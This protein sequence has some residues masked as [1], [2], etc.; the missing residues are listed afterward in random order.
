MDKNFDLRVSLEE[1]VS[2]RELT[3]LLPGGRRFVELSGRPTILADGGSGSMVMLRDVTAHRELERHLVHLG[4]ML[5][6]APYE[7]YV[8]D[9][10]TLHIRFTNVA[11]R[12]ALGYLGAEL[13][14]LTI[15]DVL[16]ELTRGDVRR[17]VTD[18]SG[19]P[20]EVVAV[21]GR[22]RRKD[23]TTY[24]V[25]AR[26]HLVSFADESAI[27][28]FAIDVSARV[29]AEDAQERLRSRMEQAQRFETVQQLAGGIAHEF[30]NLLM[31]VGGHAEMIAGFAGEDRVREWAGRIRAAQER[32]AALIQRL[33]GLARTD[34]AQPTPF[35]LG[36]AL[37]EFLPVLERT[38]GPTVHVAL[39][40]AGRDVVTIDRG[41]MEQIVLHLATNARDAMPT[42][43]TVRIVVRGPA[44][45]AGGDVEM[46]VRDTGQG[47]S[48]ET[49]RRAFDPFFTDKPHGR[50]TGLGLTTVRSIVTQAGGQVE[51]ESTPAAGT[52]ARVRLPASSVQPGPRFAA[53]AAAPEAGEAGASGDI[54]VVEDD[55]DSRA[56]VAHALTHAGYQVRAVATAEEALAWAGERQ[57]DVDLVLT[58]IALPGMT[59][60][61]LGAE[62]AARF[63]PLRVLYMSGYAQQH[64]EG[65]PPGF[66]AAAD[67]LVKPFSADTLLAAVRSVLRRPPAGIAAPPRSV[68]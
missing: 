28:L 54:L 66:D 52:I 34:V 68:T 25:E 16:P 33:Q 47:M 46:D 41:Q 12:Q 31:S 49:V 15:S 19:R 64:I 4:R 5:D 61:A 24:P 9:A 20:D 51:L 57:G 1:V 59:G 22:H 14:D 60:F 39:E 48:P 17:L 40:A 35:S 13:E 65:A 58:D 56:V 21:A 38:L 53:P 29:A 27:G 23:G 30:N 3:L 45:G 18:L 6:R 63:A 62:I 11:A 55:A 10:D 36:E 50:G 42:G 8:F 2:H 7:V 43:G 44:P 67:L 26:L 37:R 32:G